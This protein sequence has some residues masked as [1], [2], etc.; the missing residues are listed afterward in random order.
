MHFEVYKSLSTA[1]EGTASLLTAQLAMPGAVCTTVFNGSSFYSASVANFAATGISSDNVFGD[2]T[3][4]QIAQQTSTMTG[5]VSAGY[6][7]TNTIGI[8]I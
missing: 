4:A 2:N 6:V 8:A 1:T 7:A 5:S 3:S